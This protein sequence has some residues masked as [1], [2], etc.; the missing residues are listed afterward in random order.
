MQDN[1]FK[2]DP[3]TEEFASNPYPIYATLRKDYPLFFHEEWNTWLFS[4][5]QDV[6]RLVVDTRFGRT[7]DSVLTAE[8]LAQLKKDQNWDAMPN[9]S[10][11]IKV[12][13]LESEGE[14]HQT[15]RRAV[16]NEFTPAQTA[17]MHDAIQSIV[18]QAFE[19]IS[20]RET[21]DFI[22]DFVAAIPGFIIGQLLGVPEVDRPKLRRWSEDIVQYYEPERSV[23]R[24]EIAEKAVS[25]FSEYLIELIDDYRK[26]PQD[27]LISRLVHTEDAS[28]KLNERDLISNCMFILAAGH[29]S[30][31]DVVGTGM[32]AMLSNPNEMAK[33]QSDPTLIKR[34]ITEMFRFE[35]PL[36]YFHRIALEDVEY[37]G[38]VYTKGTM[39][40]LLY[41][42]AN[43]DPDQFDRPD[44]F[45]VTRNPNRHLAFGGGIHHCLGN[46]LA[47]LNM[48]VIFRTLLDRFPN[49]RLA[50]NQ[51]Q[52]EYRQG[53]QSRG[54]VSLPIELLPKS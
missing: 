54:L 23:K 26:N 2:L 36:P 45:D 7:M 1:F 12:N 52:I 15:L 22:E 18:D 3:Y 13:L 16:F 38:N 41:G 19:R 50:V 32:L 48:Q 49:T 4:R 53:I 39:I 30:T 9:H 21:V 31:I 17:L 10:K 28:L 40:A 6:R 29:G 42:A 27:N 51:E 46:H 33:I 20:S 37:D 14:L 34:A 24:E 11:Y 35:S 5:Y 43:H 25:E 47:K 8:E 44:T